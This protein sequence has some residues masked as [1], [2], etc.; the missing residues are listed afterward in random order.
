MKV[1]GRGTK[2]PTCVQVQS[3]WG[4]EEMEEENEPGMQNLLLRVARLLND[5]GQVEM[6]DAA[7]F[8]ASSVLRWEQGRTL[9]RKSREL[10]LA[11][12]GLLVLF[13]DGCLVPVLRAARLAKTPFTA[14]L[15][16]DIGEALA[17]LSQAL[18]RVESSAIAAL[19]V[20]LEAGDAER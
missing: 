20:E 18:A 19:M 3:A 13:A 7:G 2:N 14:E 5:W 4:G 8:D 12:A 16:E 6:A 11:A 1:P 15:F 17:E 9:P 10:L